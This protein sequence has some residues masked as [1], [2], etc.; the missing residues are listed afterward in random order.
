MHTNFTCHDTG[1]SWFQILCLFNFLSVCLI[2]VI[3][4]IF[5]Q[6]KH[7]FLKSNSVKFTFL[8]FLLEYVKIFRKIPRVIIAWCELLSTQR[9]SSTLYCTKQTPKRKEGLNNH[10]WE[11]SETIQSVYREEIDPY[12]SF[13]GIP[14]THVHSL[15][16]RTASGN[17]E[18]F[19]FMGTG[20]SSNLWHPV[21]L[22]LLHAW[23]K[24]W[25]MHG[26]LAFTRFSHCQ[27]IHTSWGI[28]SKRDSKFSLHS[29]K[30]TRAV[31]R[32]IKKDN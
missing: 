24:S 13:I 5:Q 19:T 20:P 1:K 23:A 25:H 16:L 2:F 32:D 4:D 31:L 14:P 26:S 18:W 17:A 3:K 12:V 28:Q 27:T 29:R 30:K 10:Q 6:G 21:C 9:N 15:A 7:S 22:T 11:L 8:Y